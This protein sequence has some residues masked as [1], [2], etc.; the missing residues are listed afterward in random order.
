MPDPAVP[1]P[2]HRPVLDPLR[3][4]RSLA[5]V[6]AL[7]TAFCYSIGFV[8]ASRHY[9]QSGV[10]INAIGNGAFLAAG[11]LFALLTIA[12]L[13]PLYLYR[14]ANVPS[15]P[16]WAVVA[17][18]LCSVAY[19]VSPAMAG[20]LIVSTIYCSLIEAFVRYTERRPI[21]RNQRIS[22]EVVRARRVRAYY[23]AVLLSVVLLAGWFTKF[24]GYL[25]GFLGGG[26][27]QAIARFESENPPQDREWLSSLCSTSPR[28]RGARCRTVYRL[29]ETER[30]VYLAVDDSAMTCDRA[31]LYYDARARCLMRK[32]IEMLST[33][34]FPTFHPDHDQLSFA[35]WLASAKPEARPIELDAG[36]AYDAS[37]GD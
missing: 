6:I 10:P 8:A 28:A 20:Y 5:E 27:P 21:K 26:L 1:G 19:G 18:G 34:E 7:P 23:F 33:I 22:V 16:S 14:I 15:L 13:L 25:P 2:V 9:T 17:L 12:S 32:P 3:D 29:Y 35:L 36:T 37:D 4:L 31:P 11:V 30:H 24:Y